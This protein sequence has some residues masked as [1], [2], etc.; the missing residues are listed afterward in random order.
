MNVS[1]FVAVNCC[2]LTLLRISMG[3]ICLA[4]GAMKFFHECSPAE[5]LAVR[6]I[7]KLTLGVM[8]ER[9]GVLLLAVWECTVGLLL[10]A[11]KRKRT[12]LCGFT[13]F[14]LF[15][16]LLFKQEPYG[17]TLAGQYIIKNIIIASA[18][19]VVWPSN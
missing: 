13:P 18:A 2:Y 12:A 3:I 1:A 6:T 15:P 4:F 10:V 7:L 16:S 9:P 11:G 8:P 5:E 14:L 17:I 19:M